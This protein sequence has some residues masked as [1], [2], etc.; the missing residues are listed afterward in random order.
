M[1]GVRQRLHSDSSMDRQ[2]GF[3]QLMMACLSVGHTKEYIGPQY[4]WSHHCPEA[5]NKRSNTVFVLLSEP[6][7]EKSISRNL[8]ASES[9]RRG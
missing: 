6:P 3:G 5:S 4:A 8:L 9:L 1:S 2:R 7:S